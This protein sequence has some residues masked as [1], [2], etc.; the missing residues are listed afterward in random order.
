[1]LPV[2]DVMTRP[3]VTVRCAASLR[4]AAVPLAEDGYAGVPVVGDDGRLAGML[5]VGDVLRAREAAVETAGAAMTA[6]AISVEISTDL[7]TVGRL[8]LQRGVRSMPVVDDENRVVGI[9]SRG[10][11][12]RLSMTSD[13]AVAV[14]VQKLL[15]NYTGKRRWIAQV[16][17]GRVTV[18]G[19]FDD[20]SERRI[21]TALARLVPGIREVRIGASP[22]ERDAE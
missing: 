7:D 3:V 22:A 2:T 6:P 10:D 12:L 18:A 20:D 15:D 21:A 4:A 14:G 9:V 1:M 11:I 17:E 16:R 5:T 13:D 8:L 19:C